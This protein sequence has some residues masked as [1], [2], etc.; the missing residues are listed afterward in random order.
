MIYYILLWRPVT[1]SISIKNLKSNSTDLV[2]YG[3]VGSSTLIR[4][5]NYVRNATPFPS[6]VISQ[7]VGHLLGDG[8][9]QFSKT[10]IT[11]YFIFTQTL[12]RFNYVWFVFQ[13]L[14]HYCG[15]YPL[16]GVSPRKGNNYYFISVVTRSYSKLLTLFNLFYEVKNG[17]VM[18]II[19]YELLPYLDEIALAYWS[20]D[21]GALCKSGF[22]LHTKGFTFLE[23]SQLVAML[24]Y[25]FT[26]ICSVQNHEGKPVIYIK[27]KSMNHFRSLV[28]PHFHPSMMYKLKT[29]T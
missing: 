15:R 4:L 16:L 7:L 3:I 10:S 25:K 27:A 29:S 23:V 6:Q 8:S 2:P 21:D 18:K 5:N 26:L 9:I 14:S 24:H 17:K 12:K 19:N 20:M 13:Q 22:Y 1:K 28:V 11:P